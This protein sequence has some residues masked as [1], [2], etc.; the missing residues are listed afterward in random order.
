ML[1]IYN[2]MAEESTLIIDEP[3]I[4]LNIDWQKILVASMQRLN[5]DAQLVL[6]THSPEI[7]ADVPDTKVFPL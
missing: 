4:S 6:A 2:L 3:E 5:P 1:F 7:M